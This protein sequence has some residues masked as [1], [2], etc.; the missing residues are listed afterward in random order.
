LHQLLQQVRWS[1]PERY[2]MPF[3]FMPIGKPT[4]G[5]PVQLEAV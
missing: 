4:D 5:L 2:E 1:V 3:Q